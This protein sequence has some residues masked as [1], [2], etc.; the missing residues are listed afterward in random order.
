MA[1]RRYDFTKVGLGALKL[2]EKE[3]KP[4]LNQHGQ[5]EVEEELY[6]VSLIYIPGYR[7]I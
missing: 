1:A 3:K 4:I 2:S 6:N 5:Y 7:D